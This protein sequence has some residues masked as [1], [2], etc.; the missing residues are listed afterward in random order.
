MT[1]LVLEYA[2]VAVPQGQGSAVPT[3]Q[4]IPFD[5]ASIGTDDVAT[6]ERAAID[7]APAGFVFH[8]MREASPL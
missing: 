5:T 2:A 6:I 4:E 8:G 1:L 7:R 3:V